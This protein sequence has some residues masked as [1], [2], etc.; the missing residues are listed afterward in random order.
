M[1][2]DTHVAT[3]VYVSLGFLWIDIVIN[4]N[5]FDEHAIALVLHILY[6]SKQAYKTYCSTHS[7]QY[8]AGLDR[9]ARVSSNCRC[10]TVS[11]LVDKIT[12]I[13]TYICS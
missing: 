2:L 6:T 9:F 4:L 10:T 1:Y 3:A 5:Y 7:S 13:Y 11:W 12:S 8:I